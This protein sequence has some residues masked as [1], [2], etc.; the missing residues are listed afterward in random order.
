MSLAIN[1]LEL[2]P[3][4][5]EEIY[6]TA[7]NDFESM[8]RYLLVFISKGNLSQLYQRIAESKFPMN[9][10]IHHLEHEVIHN[11]TM[12]FVVPNLQ[13]PSA[14]KE[15]ILQYNT[16]ECLLNKLIKLKI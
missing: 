5:E 11:D 6:S 2:H 7:I 14:S 15:Y 3:S 1:F 12:K 4:F 9:G 8:D 16:L 10:Y 13:N